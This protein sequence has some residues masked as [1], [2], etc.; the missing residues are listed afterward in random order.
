MKK[1]C[2]QYGSFQ[3]IRAGQ[4]EQE[5]ENNT[6]QYDDAGEN[7]KLSIVPE[8]LTDRL[9]ADFPLSGWIKP[10]RSINDQQKQEAD[11]DNDSGCA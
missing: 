11:D 6:G 2:G 8:K 9:Q 10:G 7:R 4:G 5:A 1:R 3:L